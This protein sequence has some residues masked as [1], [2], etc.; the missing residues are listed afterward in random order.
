MGLYDTPLPSRPDDNLNSRNENDDD[1]QQKNP[2]NSRRDTDE[3]EGDDDGDD[4]DVDDSEI[5]PM[6]NRMAKQQLFAFDANG[7]EVQDWLPPLQRRL[8]YGVGC[9]YEPTDRIVQNLIEKTAPIHPED[10]CWALE[11]CNGDIT[12]AWTRISTARRLKL[13]QLQQQQQCT[14]DDE[15]DLWKEFQTR[16][17]KLEQQQAQQQ[18]QQQQ[19]DDWKKSMKP[20][21]PWLPNP[22]PKPIDDEPWFTG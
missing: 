6:E 20:D 13:E 8:V 19:R 1:A 12:E 10:A 16:M 11:A 22:N 18:Q 14:G 9:Y 21:Q 15:E 17:K 3:N 7:K 5:L 4:D 2:T